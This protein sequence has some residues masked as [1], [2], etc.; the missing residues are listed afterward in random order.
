MYVRMWGLHLQPFVG[1]FVSQIRQK[2]LNGSTIYQRDSGRTVHRWGD[3]LKVLS[4]PHHK[5]RFGLTVQVQHGRPNLVFDERS[6]PLD[7][8]LAWIDSIPPHTLQRVSV[9]GDGW[10]GK[11]LKNQ[12][13]LCRKLHSVALNKVTVSDPVDSFHSA[14]CKCLHYSSQKWSW[15]L[16]TPLTWDY[17]E[18]HWLR[19]PPSHH[20]SLHPRFNCW[21]KSFKGFPGYTTMTQKRLLSYGV[22]HLLLRMFRNKMS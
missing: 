21:N 1:L 20:R 2:L 14:V 17:R 15:G 19:A 13:S 5:I 8:M 10:D 22:F 11:R 7:P 3:V 12:L 4:H 16:F 6:P 9:T 18:Y